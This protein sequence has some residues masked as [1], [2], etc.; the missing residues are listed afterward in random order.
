[1]PLRRREKDDT[2]P[3]REREAHGAYADP[4]HCAHVEKFQVINHCAPEKKIG[5]ALT[6]K[7]LLT[8]SIW[9]AEEEEI[10]DANEDRTE[11]GDE[12]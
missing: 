7:G 10:K 4:D 1:V 5:Y 6:E 12:A 3:E 9:D 2:R 11:A 8:I